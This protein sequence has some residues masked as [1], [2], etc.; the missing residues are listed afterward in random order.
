MS[1]NNDKYFITG[2]FASFTD[3]ITVYNKKEYEYHQQKVKEAKEKGEYS[4]DPEGGRDNL[5][6]SISK[7][8]FE[9]LSKKK[10][11][12]DHCDTHQLKI[13]DYNWLLTEGWKQINGKEPDTGKPLSFKDIYFLSKIDK[14]KY[15]SYKVGVTIVAH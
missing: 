11:T 6:I 1:K 15:T 9:I 10:V 7:L 5:N 8:T 14:D 13:V 12:I 2:K 4:F 3:Y